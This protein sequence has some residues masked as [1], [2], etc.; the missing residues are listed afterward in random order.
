MTRHGSPHPA[1][2]WRARALTT[3]AIATIALLAY[4]ERLLLARMAVELL[5]RIAQI[6]D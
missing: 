6:S 1:G 5:L 3:V 2:L 4:G